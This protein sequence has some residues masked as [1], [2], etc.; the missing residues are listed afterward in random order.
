[1]KNLGDGV[2]LDLIQLHWSMLFCYTANVATNGFHR[3][4]HECCKIRRDVDTVQ[5]EY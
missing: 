2:Y 5:V 1:M 4:N 3:V